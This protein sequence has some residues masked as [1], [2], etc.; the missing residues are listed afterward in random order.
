[1][2]PNVPGHIKEIVHAIVSSLQFGDRSVHYGIW[3][4]KVILVYT[5]TCI[6]RSVSNFVSACEKGYL[7]L[8]N[9]HLEIGRR[10]LEY[11]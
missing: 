4:K 6:E 1:M 8:F 11:Q 2:I 5:K 3:M 9:E 10:W 7:N